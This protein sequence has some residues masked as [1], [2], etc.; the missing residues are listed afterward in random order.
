MKKAQDVSSCCLINVFFTCCTVD[1]L[2]EY[3]ENQSLQY[4]QYSLHS[5]AGSWC[6]G[7]CAYRYVVGISL[8]SLHCRFLRTAAKGTFLKGHMY[9]G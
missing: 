2:Y 1:L 3:V 9:V 4:L 6:P 5:C 7:K 8:F